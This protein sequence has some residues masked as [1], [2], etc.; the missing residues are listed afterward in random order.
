MSISLNKLMIIG[1]L[2]ADPEMKFTPNGSPTTT[3]N[4]AV[5]RKF[6]SGENKE[7]KTE[8]EWFQVSTW[9]KLAEICNQHAKKG[10]RVFAMGRCKLN[11]WT[12][13]GG[14][15]H[16]RLVLVADSVLFLDR[17]TDSIPQSNSEAIEE[18][19]AEVEG[20]QS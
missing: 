9:N 14:Q 7:M 2:G 3:F 5:S 16:A 8:T 10:A 11:K 20:G 13:Q 18:I 17:K 4:V 6:A 12:D 19:P 1:N 15:N